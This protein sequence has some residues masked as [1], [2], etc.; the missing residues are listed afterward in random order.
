MLANIL[1]P[2]NN[3]DIEYQIYKTCTVRHAVPGRI[4]GRWGLFWTGGIR[5]YYGIAL[6]N[7][8]TCTGLLCTGTRNENKH[9]L[10]SFTIVPSSF[11][12]W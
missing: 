7:M 9:R 1:K 6:V 8:A 11:S 4:H 3:K 2:S 10:D 5:G 12:Q